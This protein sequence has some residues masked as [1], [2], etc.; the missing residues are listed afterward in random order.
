MENNRDFIK[1]MGYRISIQRKR[2]GLTQEQLAELSDVSPQLISNAENGTRAIS[3]DKL[4]RIS[5]AL[6]VSADYL[7]SG[8]AGDKDAQLLQDKLSNVPTNKRNAIDRI[9]DIIIDLDE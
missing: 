2:L 9:V 3:S 1:E 6:K 7:L 5:K 4:Y 8:E